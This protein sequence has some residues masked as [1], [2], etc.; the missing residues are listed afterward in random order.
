M[1]KLRR[2]S[3]RLIF[4]FLCKAKEVAKYHIHIVLLRYL[5][6]ILSLH[7]PADRVCVRRIRARNRESTIVFD[8]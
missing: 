8:A 5:C 6:D 1:V 4:I 3:Y 2:I 7:L